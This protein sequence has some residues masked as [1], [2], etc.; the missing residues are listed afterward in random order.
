[1][2]SIV[3]RLKRGWKAFLGRDAPA[4]YSSG[5]DYGPSY[6]IGGLGSYKIQSSQ[7][8]KVSA[9]SVIKNKI[10]NDAAQ[11]KMVHAIVDEDGNYIGTLPTGLNNVFNYR[12]NIDQPASAFRI[13]I[14]ESLLGEGGI[15]IVPTE[16]E[17]ELAEEDHRLFDVMEARV[18]KILKIYPSKVRFDVYTDFDGKHH[19]YVKDKEHI[20]VVENPFRSIMNDANSTAKKLERKIALLDKIDDMSASG[21]LDLIIQLPYPLKG[22]KAIADAEERRKNIDTQLSGSK[23]GIA[24][25]DVNE[26]IV[27]LNRPLENNLV[28]QIEYY[29]KRLYTEFGLTPEILNGTADETAMINYHNRVVAPVVTAVAEACTVAFIG[30]DAY[31]DGQI[32]TSFRDPF[33]LA[34]ISQIAEIA[35]KFTRNEIM[36]SNEIRSKIG[37]KPSD[38][39]NAN[40]L[41]NSNLNHPDEQMQ[42]Q[43]GQ[44]YPDQEPAQY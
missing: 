17:D 30:L 26:K 6:S 39:P 38:D 40:K 8:N 22:D 13:D 33:K 14:Y 12:A 4:E 29:D 36:T 41:R 2:G 5:A 32:V 43:Q 31:T 11:I 18:A 44:L 10:A 42:A 7:W 21:K 1:M 19:E 15:A 34:P 9:A 23:H 16:I 28:A 25:I 27:Q 20:A 3:K 37:L 35:D 24:Y